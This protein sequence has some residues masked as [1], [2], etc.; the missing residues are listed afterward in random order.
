MNSELNQINK[1]LVWAFWQ[2]LDSAEARTSVAERYCSPELEWYGPAPI[3]ALK[4]AAAFETDYWQPLQTSFP[5]LRRET[6]IFMGGQ[7]SGRVDGQG[8]GLMWVGGT[9]YLHATFD[10]DYLG[11]PATG[12]PV[13]IRWGE[14][15]RLESEKIVEI[16]LLLDLIDLMQQ[17]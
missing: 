9:G 8:D 10:H 7:S 3:N 2:A 11:I 5:D 12:K 17:A 13:K 6:H 16:Y 1:R 14:F 15:C 4:G